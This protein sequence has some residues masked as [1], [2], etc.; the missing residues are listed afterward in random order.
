MTTKIDKSG[1]AHRF[2]KLKAETHRQMVELIDLTK[3]T[4]WKPEQLRHEVRSMATRLAQSSPGRSTRGSGIGWS[5][6]S[7]TRLSGSDRWKN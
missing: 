3:L 6:K 7:M 5:T 1:N 2:Q 4:T